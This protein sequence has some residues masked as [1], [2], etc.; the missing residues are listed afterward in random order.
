MYR[1]G[2]D[3]QGRED[4]V[5]GYFILS[6]GV[7]LLINLLNANPTRS[8]ANSPVGSPTHSALINIR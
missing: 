6:V 1:D 3:L 2:G 8:K 7:N 5:K 4:G